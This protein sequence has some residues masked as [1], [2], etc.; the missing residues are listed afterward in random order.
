[1]S[2]SSKKKLRNAQEAELLTEKQRAEQ[3]EA[4]KLK[5]FSAV[6]VLVL[7]VMVVFAA[8]TAI[9]NGLMGSG[10]LL[11]N[12]TAVT[13]DDHEVSAMEYN[14]F[15][16]DSVYNFYSQYGSYASLVGLDVTK[17]LD[18]RFLFTRWNI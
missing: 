1:M 3:K 6:M 15:Y 16:I 12:T 9:S 4:K 5:A 13:V 7:A 14:C 11:R 2:A 18:Q 10:M 8:Y 17:P